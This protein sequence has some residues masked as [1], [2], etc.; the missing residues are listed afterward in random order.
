MIEKRPLGHLSVTS[1]SREAVL[2][3]IVQRIRDRDRSYCIP[4][5]VTKYGM[6]QRDV[7]LRD[8]INDAEYVLA[9]GM[10]MVWFARR[11]GYRDVQRITGIGLAERLLDVAAQQRWRLYFLG[12]TP[13]SLGETI[14]KLAGRYPGIG[15]CGSRHGYFRQEEISRIVAEINESR[16]D[17]LFLGLGL[18]QKEYFVADHFESLDVPFCLTVGGAFDIWSG[19]KKR[20]PPA[21][22]K[23]G[24]EW[25]FRTAYDWRKAST[26]ARY[27]RRYVLDVAFLPKT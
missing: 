15:F 25:F 24:L 9:D 16:P 20:T 10:P 5:N 17:V 26:L 13:E 19:Q 18:P 1:G 4:I 2:E 12:S 14:R 23:V 6:S 21:L 11:L 3:N 7:K 8:A 22:Q 27:A